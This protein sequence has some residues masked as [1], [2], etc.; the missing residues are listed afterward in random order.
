VR[1]ASY[2]TAAVGSLLGGVTGA[3]STSVNLGYTSFSD[4]GIG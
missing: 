3:A 4:Y 1:S 2:R